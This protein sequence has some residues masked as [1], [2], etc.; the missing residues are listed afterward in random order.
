MTGAQYITLSQ[1]ESAAMSL[2]TDIR[3]ALDAAQNPAVQLKHRGAVEV[4]L[5]ATA[6]S[7]GFQITPIRRDEC[8]ST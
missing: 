4:S 3:R 5:R 8:P 1:A 7:L 2:L 6:L